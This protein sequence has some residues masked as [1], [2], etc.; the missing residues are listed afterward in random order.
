MTL[1]EILNALK[2]MAVT[3]KQVIGEMGW[4]LDAVAKDADNDAWDKMQAAAKA[5]G[6][7]ETLFGVSNIDDLNKAV[8]A[9]RDMQLAAA[10]TQRDSMIDKAIGEMVTVEA[11]RPIIKRL[12]NVPDDA[13]E[14]DVK[15]AIGEMLAQDD[16]KQAMEG[17]FKQDIINP[18]TGKQA[19]NG[20]AIVKARI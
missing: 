17:V 18:V 3:P 9:A 4:S 6:E 14:E 7:M 15:K 20:I 1:Q 13:K 19:N 2:G 8:K 16:I 12:L 10:K 11:A 5:V